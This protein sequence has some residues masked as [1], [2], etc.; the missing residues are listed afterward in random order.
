MSGGEK[1]KK[2]K[3]SKRLHDIYGVAYDHAEEEP[4]DGEAD[5]QTWEAI[6]GMQ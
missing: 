4:E 3:L 1:M 2:K 6:P 5:R